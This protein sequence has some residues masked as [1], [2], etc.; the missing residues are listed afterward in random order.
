MVLVYIEVKIIRFHIKNLFV[1]WSKCK[2]RVQNSFIRKKS[3][4]DEVLEN[5]DY[6]ISKKI[7]Y[8][9]ELHP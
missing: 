4:P 1:K 3:I 6:V 9:K 2:L 5:K 7:S 8:E